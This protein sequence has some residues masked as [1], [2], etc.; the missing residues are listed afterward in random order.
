SLV[1]PS[2]PVGLLVMCIEAAAFALALGVPITAILLIIVMSNP[3]AELTVLIILSAVTGLI[4]GALVKQMGARR[5]PNQAAPV[6]GP[7]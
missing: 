1:F 3:S 5:T 6:A 7:A 2:V 4:L